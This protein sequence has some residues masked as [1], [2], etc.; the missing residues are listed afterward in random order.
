MEPLI[1]RN[2]ETW[3]IK[4]KEV[5]LKKSIISYTTYDNFPTKEVAEI[6]YNAKMDQFQKEMD[7]LRK[8]SNVKYT[9]STYL[10]YWYENVFSKRTSADG[11]LAAIEWTISKLIIPN[12]TE[13]YLISDVTPAYINQILKRC[14]LLPYTTSGTMCKKALKLALKSAIAENVLTRF[15]FEDLDPYPA[16]P[17]RYVKYSEENLKVFLSAA[18]TAHT[19]YLEILLCLLT[20]LRIGEVRGLNFSN[21]DFSKQTIRVCQQISGDV[22]EYIGDRKTTID[23]FVKPPKTESSYRTLKVPD[24]IMEE[25]SLRKQYN[26]QYFYNNN[27]DQTWMGYVCIGKNGQIKHSNTVSEACKT[28]CRANGLPLITCHGLRHMCATILLESGMKLEDI[29]HILGHKFTSTTFDIYCGEMCGSE[30]IRD[31]T[32]RMDPIYYSEER[33]VMN[34]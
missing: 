5:D 7:R 3:S 32:E 24:I 9:L 33:R 16:N 10:T 4:V 1:Y 17:P 6:V 20:G 23:D 25:L 19:H 15:D 27:V 11:Y 22:K 31:F 13:D 18:K 21:V 34:L 26:E 12:I 14:S 28:I 29:S 8:I 30:A 2:S